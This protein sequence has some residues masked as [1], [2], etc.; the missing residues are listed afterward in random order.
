M[1]KKVEITIETAAETDVGELLRR[2]RRR[3]R[4]KEI[5]LLT[6]KY[7]ALTLMAVFLLFPYVFMVSKSL[8]DIV[9]AN[10]STPTLFPT[11]GVHFKNYEVFFEYWKYFKNSLIVVA[12]N[13]IFIPL[14]GF[15][16]AYPFARRNFKG[17]KVMFS[18]GL[19]A[20]FVLFFLAVFYGVF[21][22]LAPKQTYAFAKIAQYFQ[23]LS[24]VGR[25]DLLLVYLLTIVML[26]YYCFPLQ[27]AVECFC[28]AV[29][30]EKKVWASAVLNILLFF[31]AFIFTR[32]YNM[33]Y[34]TIAG[35]LFWVFLIFADLIPVLC[36]CLNRKPR[37]GK[38]DEEKKKGTT[39]KEKGYA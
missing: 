13:G 18:Y 34:E 27:L 17:K 39:K 20:L 16:V 5:V 35:K 7:L 38:K 30:T 3:K 37:E 12:I 15:M 6:I 33:L 26:F 14:T 11:R 23:A 31:Y 1:A 4:E 25:F 10:S 28:T 29:N 2:S 32:Y 21:G 19:G 24:V 8:M 9:D 36:L 22:V